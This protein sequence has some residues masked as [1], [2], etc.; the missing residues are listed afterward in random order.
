MSIAAAHKT[1]TRADHG[2]SATD[3]DLI[4]LAIQISALFNFGGMW[5]LVEAY[6]IAITAAA[7]RQRCGPVVTLRDAL[8]CFATIRCCDP[9]PKF[10]PSNGKDL[11]YHWSGLSSDKPYRK[12]VAA[13][14]LVGAAITVGAGPQDQRLNRA[15]VAERRNNRRRCSYSG[16]R[17]S[18]MEGDSPNS[19]LYSPANRPSCQ[20]P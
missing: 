3:A 1:D 17:A 8:I 6:G 12:I 15:T 14:D 2:A 11:D 19:A 9:Q 18:I 5:A 20:K 10:V 16:G 4:V 7:R 13:M